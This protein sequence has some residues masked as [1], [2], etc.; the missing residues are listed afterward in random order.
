MTLQ[1]CLYATALD[2][3][4]RMLLAVSFTHRGHD[5]RFQNH[6]RHFGRFPIVGQSLHFNRVELVLRLCSQAHLEEQHSKLFT[7]SFSIIA[8]IPPLPFLRIL[9]KMARVFYFENLYLSRRFIFTHINTKLK[10]S[11]FNPSLRNSYSTQGAEVS[12]TFLGGDSNHRLSD[13]WR[14]TFINF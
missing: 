9:R 10:L 12:S 5:G 7:E 8:P 4:H 1:F 3:L 13:Q 2:R 11:A 14:N 6:Q